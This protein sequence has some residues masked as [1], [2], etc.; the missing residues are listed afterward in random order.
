M[1]PIASGCAGTDAGS[2]ASGSGT[3]G[4]SFN[5]GA[6]AA[7]RTGA[8]GWAGKVVAGAG[9]TS[10]S[11]GCCSMTLATGAGGVAALGSGVSNGAAGRAWSNPAGAGMGSCGPSGGASTGTDW[12][13]ISG[14]CGGSG[15]SPKLVSMFTPGI[16]FSMA[17]KPLIA[18]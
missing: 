9:G 12:P 14:T 15:R 1:G 11:W 13:G 7:G 16:L 17:I 2:L 4:T 6:A 8:G 10:L 5:T 3:E 18:V